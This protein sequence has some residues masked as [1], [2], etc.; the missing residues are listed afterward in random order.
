MAAAY[1][2]QD[3]VTT[4]I[5]QRFMYFYLVYF[6][7]AA[8]NVSSQNVEKAIKYVAIFFGSMYLLQFLLYPADVF[9]YP[10]VL[11]ERSTFRFRVD[12]FEFLI[13]LAAFAFNKLLN[14]QVQFYPLLL[15]AVVVN[16]LSGSR[17]L[18]VITA[19]SIG[20]TGYK[21]KAL[22]FGLKVFI[23]GVFLVSFILFLPKE[24]TSSITEKTKNDLQQGED[25]IRIPAAAFYLTTYNVDV[26]TWLFG[27]GVSDSHSQYGIQIQNIGEN[28]GFYLGDIGFIGEFVRFGIF[29]FL[30]VCVLL[31]RAIKHSRKVD[32]VLNS[33]LIAIT[34]F[35]VISWPFGHGP[36]II[37]FASVLYLINK[38]SYEREVSK[39]DANNTLELQ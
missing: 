18:L 9:Y 25:Y 3:I 1:H 2:G 22:S 4:L 15:L 26:P 7:L 24:Y 23:V 33:Y 37:L 10:K 36:G 31:Y 39:V 30:I 8:L 11:I 5:E 14:K 32:P 13:F 19:I 16:F 20:L 38:K 12:G 17:Y 21:S 34:L 27:N 29:Y 6:A 35:Y 28:L